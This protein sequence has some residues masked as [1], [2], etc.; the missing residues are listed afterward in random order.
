MAKHSDEV[1]AAVVAA[2][3]SGQS[4]CEVAREYNIPRGTVSAWKSRRGPKTVATDAT[5]K[6]EIGDLILEY[7][8][9]NL[10]TLKVQAELFRDRKWISRQSA[11][12]AAVLHGVMT[13]KAIRILEALSKEEQNTQ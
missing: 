7:L 12:S 1:K 11:D 5:Q 8:R 13:D 6:K 2:L 3:L 4:V 10:E 9:A